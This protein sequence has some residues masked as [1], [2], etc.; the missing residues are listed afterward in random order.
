MSL[1]IRTLCKTM[2]MNRRHF[3]TSSFFFGL[4]S[5]LPNSLFGK[6]KEPPSWESIIDWARWAPSVHNLQ[7]YRV[8]VIS[9]TEAELLCD[10]KFLLPVG[11]PKSEFATAVFGV[12]VESLSIAA[13][14]HGYKVS[15]TEF[16]EA[17]SVDQEG[18]RPF[19]KITMS[20]RTTMENLAPELLKE[21]RTAR[22]D[23]TGE[24]LKTSTIRNCEE[25]VSSFGAALFSTSDEEQVDHL[26]KINQAT[27]FEDLSHTP[28]REELDSLFRYSKK[29]AEAEKTGLW[30]KCMGF[31]GKLVKSVFRHHEKWTKGA[32]KKMLSSYYGSTYKGT[33]TI[34]WV[35]HHWSSSMDQYE[36]GRLLCRLWLQLT[37]EGAYMHPF[38]SLITNPTAFSALS[39]KLELD[40]NNEAPLAFVCRAG[41]SKVPPRSFRINTSDILIE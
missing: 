14:P 6:T 30:T 40:P 2:N 4:A 35:Q 24:P 41:Y 31:P 15:L 27:L 29:E 20:E 26:V 16:I 25:L 36:F 23:Y 22:T 12:F 37:K 28:M 38:G 8:K 21:R 34:M 39:Q 5:F 19:G 13:A 11:D 3:I 1:K 33:A 17:P 32:R 10:S 18:I 9:E 7:P